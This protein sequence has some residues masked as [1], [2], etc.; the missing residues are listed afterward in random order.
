MPQLINPPQKIC[1]A[2]KYFSPS[3]LYFT[4]SANI[5]H[6]KCTHPITQN[7]DI[8]TGKVTYPTIVSARYL[9]PCNVQAALY[10]EQNNKF[11]KFTNKYPIIIT[12]IMCIIFAVYMAAY[13]MLLQTIIYS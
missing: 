1:T 9:D 3:Y 10:E 11:I 4:N 2:C 7:V 12:V 13:F 6:G 8:V 5:K